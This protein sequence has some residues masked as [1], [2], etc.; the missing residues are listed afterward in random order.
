M[1]K[2]R[3]VVL[4][5]GK[6]QK[7]GFRSFIKKHAL[8]LGITGYAENLPTGEVIVVAEGEDKGLGELLGII[9]KESPAYIK[10]NRITKRKEEYGGSFTDFER[11][12]ADVMEGFEEKS[13]RDLLISMVSIMKASDSKLEVGVERLEEIST[14]QDKT[15]NILG[16]MNNKQDKM[17][18]K[19][20]ETIQAIKEESEKTR[21]ALEKHLARDIARLYEEIDDIKATLA[22]VVERVGA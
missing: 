14:K 11:K 18:E 17:L 2:S 1:P 22:R 12:G 5:E 15:L 3:F 20:D 8:T 13:S 16:E 21:G 6:I 7:G 10:V 9:E 19:Q 4:I